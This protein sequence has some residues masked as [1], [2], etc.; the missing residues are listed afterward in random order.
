MCQISQANFTASNAEEGE[1]YGRQSVR[2]FQEL[3]DQWATG[4]MLWN[5]GHLALLRKDLAQATRLG[6]ESLA[7][8]ERVN[9]QETSVLPSNLLG[10][11]AFSEGDV[12]QAERHFTRSLAFGDAASNRIARS[13]TDQKL[14]QV[15]LA[16]EE[17]SRAL[18]HFVAAFRV[19]E[20][21]SDN[22]AVAD[23]LQGMALAIASQYAQ[24]L[25]HLELAI[26]LLGAAAQSR[27][28]DG[29]LL[30]SVLAPL[31]QRVHEHL[32]QALT[33]DQI[34]LAQRVGQ[35]MV[36]KDLVRQVLRLAVGSGQ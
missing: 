20:D 11:I 30:P 32:H 23:A 17:W 25:A 7:C 6:H 19:R 18:S 2:L 21:I 26:R 31:Y 4:Y 3:N 9:N 8:F 12:V 36:T 1:R 29:L 24:S 10:D 34:Q 14:G 35:R 13:W 28:G 16:R 27:R 33:A 22:E 15:L 5:L